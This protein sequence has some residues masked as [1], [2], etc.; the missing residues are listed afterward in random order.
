MSGC[1]GNWPPI[2]R[3]NLQGERPHRDNGLGVGG[4]S[5]VATAN[6]PRSWSRCRTCSWEPEELLSRHADKLLVR[7]PFCSLSKFLFNMSCPIR[8]GLGQGRPGTP[9][10][11]TRRR[12]MRAP[13]LHPF[14]AKGGCLRDERGPAFFRRRVA[15]W[16]AL[17]TPRK[18]QRVG[19]L[20]W[21]RRR[22]V[23]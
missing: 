19:I 17:R 16:E 12:L 4:A 13:Q 7:D 15:C 14:P 8:F 18:R 2:C 20:G 3:D 6:G 9:R 23:W 1:L 22:S 21:R 11:A 10:D 5:Y